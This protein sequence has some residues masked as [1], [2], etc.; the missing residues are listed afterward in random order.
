MFNPK[1][2]GLKRDFGECKLVAINGIFSVVKCDFQQILKEIFNYKR[3]EGLGY[4]FRA[5]KLGEKWQ[6][7]L[8]QFDTLA[9]EV[10]VTN[11]KI[12]WKAESLRES[13]QKRQQEMK[14]HHS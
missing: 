13:H 6:S 2:V 8:W 1:L 11:G 9:K 4:F 7:F 3:N 5:I 12:Y 14:W 10:H